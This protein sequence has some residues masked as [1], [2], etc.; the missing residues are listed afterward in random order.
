MTVARLS[1]EPSPRAMRLSWLQRRCRALLLHCLG[2][3]RQGRLTIVEGT[4][5]LEFGDRRT[6]CPH[7]GRHDARIIVRDPRLYTTVCL[8]GTLGAAEAY[9]QGLWD[10]PDLVAT[11]RF[12]AV[13][14]AAMSAMDAGAARLLQ[15]LRLAWRWTRRNTRSGSRRNIAEHYDLSNEFFALMLDPTLTYS[16]GIF[17]HPD[18]TMEEAS[19]A[20]YDRICRKL[21]LKPSDH[22]LEIGA[23]WGGFALHAA[24][25]YGCRVTTTTISRQQYDE[26]LP[27]IKSAGLEHRVTLLLSDYRDLA[28]AYD[29]L[30]SIEMIEAVGEKMLDTYFAQCSTLLKPHGMMLLQAITI[31]DQRYDEYRKSID[32]INRYIFP[33]GFLPSFSAISGSLRRKTDLQ[34][35]H[36]EEFGS[37]YARTLA[38]WREAFRARLD[39]VRCL[40]FDERFIRMWDYYLCYCQTGFEERQIGVSQMVLTKPD[41]RRAPLLPELG[42]ESAR[43]EWQPRSGMSLDSRIGIDDDD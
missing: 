31:P 36:L 11:L 13:N 22:V 26:A 35:F 32:F 27:R 17:P 30:V 20:K 29:K 23:G 19:L 18:A 38:L 15:P 40:G 5:R 8:G 28:G 7:P 1:T 2:K 34:L 41:C 33:G 25:R 14:A 21:Q 10:T 37:H 12:F 16:S 43:R 24:S 42:D 9:L 6:D 3:V 4:S 39:R